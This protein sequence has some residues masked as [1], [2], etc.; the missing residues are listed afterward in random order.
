MADV[1]RLT[2]LRWSVWADRSLLAFLGFGFIVAPEPTW[3]AW[4]YVAVMPFGAW[5]LWRGWRPDWTDPRLMLLVGIIAWSTLTLLWAD[6]PG[7][8]VARQWLWVWNGL[9]TGTFLLSVVE[10]SERSERVR[11]VVIR[12]IVACAAANAVFSIVRFYFHPTESGRLEGWAETRNAIL[13]ASIMGTCTMLA[14]GQW[15]GR[16]RFWPIWAA[17]IPLFMF[18]I[19]LTDSRGPL[20][21]VL[22]ASLV[23]LPRWRLRTYAWMCLVVL[24]AVS[25]IA[26]W[27]HAWLADVIAHMLERGTSYR[28]EIWREA[29]TEIVRRPLLGHGPTAGLH[30]DGGFGHH[31]HNLYL[32]AWYYSGGVGL[33]LLL[34]ALVLLA[35][36]IAHLPRSV[37]RRPE[38]LTCVGLLLHAVLSG[39][40]DLSQIIKGPGELWYIIWFPLAFVAAVL[41]DPAV[42]ASRIS[43]PTG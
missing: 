24:A 5:R 26:I 36:G 32:S 23:F 41:R 17:P 19:W 34:A 9:C 39:M 22:L 28:L 18:F 2:A 8:P 40:T 20:I 12:I 29:L 7:P 3:A 33:A 14:L 15:V 10:L 30:I 13:G 38:N 25:L 37:A 31:P 6:Q 21:A 42:A 35:R 4:F 27:Q 43:R 11:N 16:G 1:N